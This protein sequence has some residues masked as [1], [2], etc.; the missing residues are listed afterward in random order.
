MTNVCTLANIAAL[1]ANV[2]GA[3]MPVIIVQG[4]N[5]PADG[6]E[7]TFVLRTS[8]TDNGGTI[9]VDAGGNPYWR[10]NAVHLNPRMF[11][12]TGNGST[13]DTAALQ[14]CINAVQ[15]SPISRTMELGYGYFETSA[16]LT[17]T[18][19]IV[20]EG[21]GQAGSTIRPTPGIVGIAA[22]TNSPGIMR[23]FTV[24][25]ITPQSAGLYGITVQSTTAQDASFWK[26]NNVQVV[27]ANNGFNLTNIPFFSM[28]DCVVINAIG[29][30]I[31]VSNPYSIDT[32]DSSITGCTFFNFSGTSTGT[33]INYL[34]GGGL[35]ISDNKFG[36]LNYGVGFTYAGNSGS[37]TPNTAQLLITGNSFDTMTVEAIVLQRSTNTDLFNSVIVANNLFPDCRFGLNVPMDANG[38]WLSELVFTGNT[39][40]DNGAVAYGTGVALQSTQSA[41]IAGNVLLTSSETGSCAVSIGATAHNTMVGNNT[42][43][44]PGTTIYNVGVNTV[45]GTNCH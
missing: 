6:G 1:R 34:S 29:D 41:T 13:D 32:G 14:A 10:M 7:G 21:D 11:G 20:I 27:G 15:V 30:Y 45:I 28:R 12:A 3:T 9:I 40:I 42:W 31:S 43:E 26:F 23:D 37:L 24:T 39:W 8:G 4:Y 44:G 5:T 2:G 33:G 22:S 18:S 38:V 17:I 19:A 36:N 25:Y 35:R 16:T